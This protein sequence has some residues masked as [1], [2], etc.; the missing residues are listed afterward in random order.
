MLVGAQIENDRLVYWGTLGREIRGVVVDRCRVVLA[1]VLM[2][3]RSE[4]SARCGEG[5]KI[6]DGAGPQ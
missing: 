2:M 4:K 1:R 6:E 3:D 5:G